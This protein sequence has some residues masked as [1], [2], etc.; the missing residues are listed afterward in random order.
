MALP[1]YCYSTLRLAAPITSRCRPLLALQR[2]AH[3]HK[4]GRA[5]LPDTDVRHPQP[6]EKVV[7]IESAE[8]FIT[9]LKAQGVVGDLLGLKLLSR[10]HDQECKEV[11]RVKKDNMIA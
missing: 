5:K 11:S 4:S 3:W 10:L 1:S 9:K 7:S 8:R 6:T 2:S